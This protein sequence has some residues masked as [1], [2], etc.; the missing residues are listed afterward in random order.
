MGQ[1]KNIHQHVPF[2]WLGRY[3]A[4]RNLGQCFFSFFLKAIDAE[5]ADSGDKM[6]DDDDIFLII[7]FLL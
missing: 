2:R 3:P 7:I 5:E 1:V 4:D 6:N